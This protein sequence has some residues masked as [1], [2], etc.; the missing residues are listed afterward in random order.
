MVRPLHG[1]CALALAVLAGCG[2]SPDVPVVDHP[3]WQIAT[4]TSPEAGWKVAEAADQPLLIVGNAAYALAP[5]CVPQRYWASAEGER[6]L[7]SAADQ[8]LTGSA[9][10]DRRLGSAAD[11][12]QLGSVA[13]ARRMGSASDQ[14][15][16]G[17]AEDR[18]L[19]GAADAGR[20]TG[21]AQD[22]RLFGSD[23]RGR[24]FGAESVRR[25]HGATESRLRCR[26]A[27]SQLVI[28][29]AGTRNG[30]L[31]SPRLRGALDGVI[32]N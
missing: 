13:D 17:A 28:T 18:R 16:T 29:G 23:A 25:L 11:A 24:D 1:A 21:S 10:D 3:V 19:G 30:Y 5:Q 32:L 7:G 31:Y 27:G 8:R 20:L 26:L 9:T 15:L 6:R 2:S 4:V 12:R 14:R 22:Q